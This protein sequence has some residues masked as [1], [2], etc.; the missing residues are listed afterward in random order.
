MPEK[1]LTEIPRNWRDYYEK[2][3]AALERQNLD[4]AITLFNQVLQNEPSFYECREALRAAQ[5][6]KAGTATS[7]FRRVL[8]TA[9]SSPLLAKGQIVLRNHPVEAIHVA[10]QILNSDPNNVHAHKLLAEAALAADFPRTA[11]LS[12]EIALKNSPRD[13]DIAMR[14]GQALV[15]AGQAGRAEEILGELQRAR[16]TDSTIAQA[17][18]NASA[19]KTM[20]D[21]GYD[22]LADGQGSY[23]DI[24]KNEAEAVALEQ[25]KRQVK[26]EDVA[27]RLI[28]EYETQLAAE[29]KNLKLLRSIGE[30]Y[31]E[32]KEFDRAL[33]YYDRIIASEGSSDGSLDRAIVEVRLKKLEQ[34]IEQLDPADPEHQSKEAKIRAEKEAYY[35]SQCQRRAAR[36]PTDLQIRFDLGQAYF[37]AG[38]VSEAILELQKAKANPHLRISALN[39]LGQCFAR[40]RMFDLATRTF[41]TAI[42]EKLVFDDEKKELIYL[43]GCALEQMG[44]AGEA[45][46]QFKQIYEVDIGYKDVAAKVDAYYAGQ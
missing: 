39:F 9:S 11:V 27:D 37:H 28:R 31:V 21:G 4:Y 16:P 1:K 5:L 29:P 14:L 45:I 30:I 41:Q 12:L 40:R 19:S 26:T 42:E 36:Y 2:G 34:A 10:E 17:L 20:R 3:R 46:E 23:R 8:G 33:E 22:A 6:R 7:F 44:K 43:L 13:K 38:K 35:L 24:L 25:E 18:K 32:K 15:G